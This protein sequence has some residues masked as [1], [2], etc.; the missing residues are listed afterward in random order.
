Q[1]FRCALA[2]PSQKPQ[3]SAGWAA[4]ERE[5]LR[6][7][8]NEGDQTSGDPK[9]AIPDLPR[10]SPRM[11]ARFQRAQS[12]VEQVDNTDWFDQLNTTP[13][14]RI[15]AGLGTRVV[16]KDQEP[17]MQAAW[18]QVGKINLV[19]SRLA[20]AQFARFAAAAVYKG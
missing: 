13:T 7:K 6:A 20:L 17:L 12:R 14:F 4:D 2:S 1:V 19:N 3:D 18:A 16:Q 10:V 15:A 5:Q 11:Y 8:L 9:K